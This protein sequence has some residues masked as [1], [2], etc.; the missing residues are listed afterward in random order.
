MVRSAR[1][2]DADSPP[3]PSKVRGA[4]YPRVS[5]DLRVTFRIKAP[6]AKTVQLRPGGDDNGLGKSPFDMIRGEDG[7]LDFDHPAGGSRVL[8]IMLASEY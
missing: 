1:I 3:A 8:T 4:E 7:T 2:R 6:E 5:P